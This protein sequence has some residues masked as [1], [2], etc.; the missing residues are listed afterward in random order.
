MA[1]VFSREVLR[2]HWTEFG[3]Q[4]WVRRLCVLASQHARHPD[5]P[6]V[7]MAAIKFDRIRREW[8]EARF[9]ESEL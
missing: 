4:P 1:M 6:Q 7:V 8:P 2:Q 3:L 9:V 5:A